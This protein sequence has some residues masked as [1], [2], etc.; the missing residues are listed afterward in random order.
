M[1]V[2]G[3]LGLGFLVFRK[4]GQN[5]ETLKLAKVGLAKV[6]QAHNWPKSV[7]EL[8]GLAKVGHDHSISFHA[9]PC[10]KDCGEWTSQLCHLCPLW[11]DAE[12]ATHTIVQREGGEQGDPM[13]PFFFSL[14]TLHW[15]RLVQDEHLFAY[16][17]DIHVVTELERARTVLTLVENA[18]LAWAGIS[19]HQ[20]KTKIWNQ[21]GIQPPGSEMLER[22]ARV[23]DQLRTCGEVQN[24]PHI[25]KAS[26]FWAHCL[27][28]L[29]L[30]GR[31]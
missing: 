5:T 7:K 9:E 16:L 8:A 27:V 10:W 4:F 2:F 30:F 6:G 31:T 19:I 14:G 22:L 18:L 17:D 15:S 11:E 21:A 13:V 28:T 25:C 24:C 12:G 23:V 1:K 3:L 29:T 26:K 20:R